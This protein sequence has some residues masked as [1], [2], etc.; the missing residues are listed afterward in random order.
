MPVPECPKCGEWRATLISQITDPLGERYYCAVCAHE[1]RTVKEKA[2][3][4][5]PE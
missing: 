2:K 1:F 5:S 4:L 3:I